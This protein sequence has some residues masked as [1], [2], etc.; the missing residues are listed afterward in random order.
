M[1]KGTG[2]N[3][4]LPEDV[5]KALDQIN[6]K[7]VNGKLEPIPN[8]STNEDKQ[9]KLH[10]FLDDPQNIAKAAEGSMAKRQKLFDSTNELELRKVLRQV[11][12][13]GAEDDNLGAE[14]WTM[15]DKVIEKGIK[16]LSELIDKAALEELKTMWNETQHDIVPKGFEQDS[17]EARYLQKRIAQLEQQTTTKEETHE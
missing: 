2:D 1:S 4:Y 15:S 10:A 6:Y 7:W 16:H 9:K 12:D 5:Q 13:A 17:I 3:G 14:D 11:R 8:P